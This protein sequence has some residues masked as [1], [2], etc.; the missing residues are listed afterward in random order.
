VA[1]EGVEP[2]AEPLAVLVVVVLVLRVV[3]EQQELQTQV[4]VVEGVVKALTVG[5]QEA[6]V[7]SF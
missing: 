4:A 3:Q 2:L 6:L 7:L 1:V 5:V